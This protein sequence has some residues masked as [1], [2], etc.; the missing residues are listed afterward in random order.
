MNETDIIK[1]V[2]FAEY[3]I[4]TLEGLKAEKYSLKMAIPFAF[5]LFQNY[6]APRIVDEKGQLNDR[7]H[8]IMNESKAV[9]EMAGFEIEWGYMYLL[10]YIMDKYVAGIDYKTKNEN[11]INGLK[12]MLF[13]KKY[14]EENYAEFLSTLKITVSSKFTLGLYEKIEKFGI[15]TTVSESFESSLCNFKESFG[16][17]INKLKIA[18]DFTRFLYITQYLNNNFSYDKT[19]EANIEEILEIN[20]EKYV[21]SITDTCQRPF[22][23]NKEEGKNMCIEEI[24][25][26]FKDEL[27]KQI[28][29]AHV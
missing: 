16:N 1:N 24:I 13:I 8:T 27:K 29:R 25:E 6:V 19:Y 10:R 14:I 21:D 23:L 11:Q 28:G 17:C 4:I 18:L 26:V 9:Y 12:S 5:W 2:K 22:S 3:T 7:V 20:G 15:L